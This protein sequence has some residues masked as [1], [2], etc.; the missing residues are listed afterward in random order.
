MSSSIT[1]TTDAAKLINFVRGV[2]T[3]DQ[4]NDKNTTESRHKL[5]DIYRSKPIIVGPPTEVNEADI[6]NNYDD[7]FYKLNNGYNNFVN[8]T[9]CGTT[10]KIRREILLAGSNGGMLHAFDTSTGEE[11][12]GFIPPSL[13]NKLPKIISNTPNYTNSIYGVDGTVV[14]KD[15]Y[16][17]G[18][19]RTV[20]LVGLGRGGQSYFA[21]DISNPIAPTHLFTIENDDFRQVV[22]F[23]NSS[24]TKTSY[25]YTFGSVSP[26]SKDYSK[27]GESWSTPRIFRINVNGTQK[28][29]AA[30]GAGYNGSVNPNLGSAVFIM[31][32]ENEGNV[33]SKIDISD[34][35]NGIA[36]SVPSDLVVVTANGTSR[37][38]YFGAMI[39]ALDLEGKITKIDVTSTGTTSSS[40]SYKSIR[41]FD[42]QTTTT[43]GR[44]IFTGAESSI[45]KSGNFWL[46]YGTGDILKIQ[47]Q[48]SGISNKLYG[49]KDKDFPLMNLSATPG[50]IA[51]CKNNTISSAQNCPGST[52]FG[53]YIDLPSNQKVSAQPTIKNQTVYFPIYEPSTGLNVCSAGQALIKATS[54]TCGETIT[55]QGNA[56]LNLG[57]GV[58][59]KVQTIGTKIVVGISGKKIETSAKESVVITD[60]VGTVESSVTVEAWREN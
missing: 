24:G 31:D 2:D 1:S 44:Y 20:A 58:A 55:F 5:N 6:N 17:G 22:N 42:S 56:Y 18:I 46:Y 60:Q 30:F 27:L 29:V 12:W 14:V 26:S 34:L 51:N 54:T 48:T 11:L 13:L 43:N 50:T 7:V 37:A 36:N 3:Y 59:T 4:D 21:L 10:C 33:L 9:K 45:D 25:L 32:L 28:W 19:W 15:I 23:W 53:W 40:P 35:S 39:Y 52:D 38:S 57:G 16:Y 47:D 41:L 8:S 49:I